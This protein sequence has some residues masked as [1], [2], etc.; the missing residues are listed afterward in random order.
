MGKRADFKRSMRVSMLTVRSRHAGVLLGLTLLFLFWGDNLYLRRGE[1]ALLLR[2]GDIE[3]NPGPD[4]P[5]QST[6]NKMTLRQARL[7]T[8]TVTS[9]SSTPAKELSLADVMATLTSMQATNCDMNAK[10]DA[11][12]EDVAGLRQDH[13]ALHEL[14]SGLR[15]EVTELRRKNDFLEKKNNDLN[16]R[17]DNLERKCDDLECRSKRNNLIFY[18]VVK[19]EGETSEECEGIVRELCTDKL[20]LADDIG[21]DRVHRLSSK[22]DAP[23]IVRLCSYKHKVNILKAKQ[24]LR[25]S[26]IFIGEDFSLRVRDIRRKLGPHLKNARNEGKQVRMIYDHL[27]I[28]GK[29]YA[30]DDHDSLREMK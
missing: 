4:L 11:V 17:V 8:S 19:N 22:K 15:E 21:F 2:C 27:I 24:K 6:S 30:L 9:K 1:G 29:R 16:A 25:G 28:E 7:S 20:E 10:L 14:V 12:K 23:I 18:G 3:A 5:G 13:S 26:D